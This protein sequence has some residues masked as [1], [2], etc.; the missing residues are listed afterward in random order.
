MLLR[1]SWALAQISC[2]EKEKKNVH[3]RRLQLQF[4]TTRDAGK[5]PFIATQLK[6]S[7]AVE[8]SCAL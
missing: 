2:Y 4:M 1:V 7:R 8:L 5:A 3:K 6:S